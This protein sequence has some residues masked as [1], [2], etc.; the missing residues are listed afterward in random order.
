MSSS[1]ATITA[2]SSPTEIVQGFF[3]AF[4]SGDLDSLLAL[5]ADEVDWDVPG[6]PSVPWT[7]RRTTKAELAEFFAVAGQEVAA[8]EEFAVDTVVAQ[9]VTAVA[10]GRFTHVIRRTGK[11]FSSQFALHVT[12]ADGRITLYHMFED[13]HA[14]AEAFAA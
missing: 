1:T 8:T 12:V 2:D 3:T 9:G 13:G 10:L 7:G 4:G 5:F 11:K 6:A 14:A